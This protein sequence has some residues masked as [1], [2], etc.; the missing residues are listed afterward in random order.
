MLFEQIRGGAPEGKLR[1]NGR[2]SKVFCDSVIG[3]LWVLCYQLGGKHQVYY[4]H[5]AGDYATAFVEGAFVL[6]RHM[7]PEV[8]AVSKKALGERAYAWARRIKPALEVVGLSEMERR[9]RRSKR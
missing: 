8:E 5:E 6:M 7:P 3:H 2:P 1:R 9:A 4:R